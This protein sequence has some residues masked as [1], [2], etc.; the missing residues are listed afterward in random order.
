MNPQQYD[1]AARTARL[2]IEKRNEN[3]H[4]RTPPT[5]EQIAELI[6]TISDGYHTNDGRSIRPFL[7]AGAQRFAHDRAE[8]YNF[9]LLEI[10]PYLP[11]K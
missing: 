3:L 6:R 5:I 10:K 7:L 8:L 4:R 11:T 9:Y 2:N 1:Q